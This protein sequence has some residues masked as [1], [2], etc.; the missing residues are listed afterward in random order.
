M[1][2]DY[3]ANF[4]TDG[5][6]LNLHD[7][8]DNVITVKRVHLTYINSLYFKCQWCIYPVSQKRYGSSGL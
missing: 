2:A 8:H 3:F 4:I 7:Q 6:F 5:C 1:I